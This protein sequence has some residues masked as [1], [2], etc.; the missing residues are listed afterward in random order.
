MEVVICRSLLSELDCLGLWL[1]SLLLDVSPSSVC[2]IFR[3]GLSSSQMNNL[4]GATV[5]YI[6]VH[7]PTLIAVG[8]DHWFK[9]GKLLLVGLLLHHYCFFLVG[10]CPI[11]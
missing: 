7:R 5:C 4:P 9:S 1:N 8:I 3:S 10:H 6:A 11:V 2:G